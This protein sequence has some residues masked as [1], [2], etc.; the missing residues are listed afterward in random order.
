MYKLIPGHG[1]TGRQP[2]HHRQSRKAAPLPSFTCSFIYAL[3]ED[4]VVLL[5]KTTPESAG[6]AIS[7]SGYRLGKAVNTLPVHGTEFQHRFDIFPFI[8]KTQWSFYQGTCLK[9][10]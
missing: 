1:C 3:V 9:K 10:Q 6:N 4:T 2:A 5:D 7:S 8:F